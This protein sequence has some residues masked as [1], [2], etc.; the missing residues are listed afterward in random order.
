VR[1]E[2]R[3]LGILEPGH[4]IGTALALRG[5][6]SPVEVTFIAPAR[7]MSWPLPSLLAFMDRR[8]DLRVALQ[9]LASHDLTR[10]I[11]RLLAER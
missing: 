8:P 11:D 2:N 6:P 7:Y 9:S 1:K 10:K 3:P 4:I 5:V